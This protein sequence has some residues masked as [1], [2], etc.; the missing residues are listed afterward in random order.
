MRRLRLDITGAVQGVGFRPYVYHLACSQALG[1]FVCNTGDGAAIEI[2]GTASALD[3]FLH[4]LGMALPPH[5]AIDR[6]CLTALAP[7]GEHSFVIAPSSVA[8]KGGA[9]VLADLATCESCLSEVLD[10]ADRRYLYPFTSCT[11]C[12]PRY[13]IIE[14][15][16]YDRV[17]TTMRHFPMCSACAAEY[18]NPNCRRFHAEPIACP[19]CG[20]QLA[21]WNQAGTPIATCYAALLQA[22][23]ALR[24]GLIVALKGLGGFQLLVDAT[25]EEAVRRL[26]LRK[27]RPRKPFAIMVPSLTTAEAVGHVGEIERRLLVSSAAPIVLIGARPDRWALT[28]G[29][30]PGNPTLGI[31]M[32]CTPLHHLLLRELEFPVIATSGNRGNSPIIADGAE[33]LEQLGGLADCFLVHDR[34]ILRPIDDSV[35]RVMAGREVVLRRARGYASAPFLRRDVSE[36]VLALGGQQ[37][38]ALAWGAA[39]RLF[40]GPHI[41][42]L[43]ASGTR[44]RLARMATD[45]PSLHAITPLTVACDMHPDYDSTRVAI[46]SGSPVTRVPHHLAHVLACM[47]DNDLDEPVLGVTWDVRGMAPMALFGVESFWWSIAAVSAASPICGHSV[48]PAERLRCVSHVEPHSGSSTRPSVRLRWSSRHFLR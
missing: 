12:G 16:P 22:A 6:Q 47:I 7:R 27:Q 48:C 18:S 9:L 31:M 37:K 23:D 10:P 36:P 42:D 41:G 8:G 28:P 32:P 3:R 25:N 15:L 39:G 43:S 33:A 14:S 35:V 40:V 17:R 4:H 44:H 30:A 45:L 2:E 11:C 5:A 21:L 34:P 19:E 26:R 46:A 29:V 24:R 1:G 20:P 38:S 13:S